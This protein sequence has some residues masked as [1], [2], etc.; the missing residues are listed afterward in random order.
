MKNATPAA[1]PS[2]ADAEACGYNALSAL[3]IAYDP[4]ARKK[5][6]VES[7]ARSPTE[8]PRRAAPPPS[9]VLRRLKRGNAAGKHQAQAIRGARMLAAVATG[10]RAKGPISSQ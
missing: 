3:P 9:D 2:G 10:R 1:D 4:I 6:S 7:F 8:A 5:Q